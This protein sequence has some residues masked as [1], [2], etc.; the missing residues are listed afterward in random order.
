MISSPL[1]ITGACADTTLPL[2]RTAYRAG[3]YG[4][5]SASLMSAEEAAALASVT[6][7]SAAASTRNQ[8]LLQSDPGA[9]RHDFPPVFLQLGWSL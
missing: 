9:G 8:K 5:V 4:A 1:M 3:W 6:H 7:T 2:M